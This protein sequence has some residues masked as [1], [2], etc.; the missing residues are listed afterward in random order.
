MRAL[1][2]S[3]AASSFSSARSSFGVD[4]IMQ[5]RRAPFGTAFRSTPPSP[6]M[7]AVQYRAQASLFTLRLLSVQC[8]RQA[9]WSIRCRSLA[10]SCVVPIP[11]P[12]TSILQ[13]GICSTPR[14]SSV[15]FIFN[16]RRDLAYVAAT[17]LV[18]LDAVWHL[19]AVVVNEYRAGHVEGSLYGRAIQTGF[20]WG[21]SG[22]TPANTG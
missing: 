7:T 5:A 19:A 8:A 10:A 3:Y 12:C 2:I 6:N 4:A 17:V 20:Q 15:P 9:G 18:V 11:P 21:G 22:T 1:G 16:M 14:S 13:R